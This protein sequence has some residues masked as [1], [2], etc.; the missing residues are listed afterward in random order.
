MTAA[1]TVRRALRPLGARDF[2]ECRTPGVF[3][4]VDWYVG[5]CGATAGRFVGCYD[6]VLS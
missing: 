1:G 4:R 2:G 3:G 5:L 6:V